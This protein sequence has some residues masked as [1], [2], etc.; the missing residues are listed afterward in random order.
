MLFVVKAGE[1]DSES[2][3]FFNLTL[4]E[5]YFQDNIKIKTGYTS[6]ASERMLS[7]TLFAHIMLS[8]FHSLP[9]FN[10]FKAKEAR[11]N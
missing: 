10:F 2:C 11:T 4:R 9:F 5:F 1:T 8:C 7:S 3:F 6:D